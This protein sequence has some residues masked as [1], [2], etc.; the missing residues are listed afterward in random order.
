MS[1]ASTG[2]SHWK[3]FLQIK[4]DQESLKLYTSWVHWKNQCRSTKRLHTRLWKIMNTNILLTYL[5]KSSLT[6]F[7]ALVSFFIPGNIS[8]NQRFPNVFRGNRKRPIP[9]NICNLSFL[10]NGNVNFPH[11]VL[12]VNLW[13]IMFMKWF[14]LFNTSYCFFL[15]FEACVISSSKVWGSKL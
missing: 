5:L 4:L 7:M 6:H 11:L 9:W 2:S 10:K 3:V 12:M 8:E 15:Q 14:S 13:P 1:W